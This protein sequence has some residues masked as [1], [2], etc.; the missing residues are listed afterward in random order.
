MLFF[1]TC[2]YISLS[3]IR[4]F[5]WEGPLYG[6]PILFVVGLISLIALFFSGVTGRIELFKNK[7]DVMMV[8]FASAIAMSHLSHGWFGGLQKSLVG[9]FPTFACYFMVAHSL[10]TKRKI[11]IFIILLVLLT[12]FLAYEGWLQYERGY[13]DGGVTPIHQNLFNKT[14]GEIEGK[15]EGEMEGGINRIR[16]YGMFNDP[17]DLGLVFVLV[18]PFILD[19][20]F[21]KKLILP[22]FCLPFIGTAIYL[23]HSR[24]TLLASLASIFCYIV[25]RYKS[26][27]GIILGIIVSALLFTLGSHGNIQISS[28]EESAHQRL[29]VWY[30]GFQMFK[31]N[32]FFGVGHDRFIDFNA[33]GITAHNSYMLVLCELGFFGLFFFIGLIYIPVHWLLKRLFCSHD[34][35]SRGQLSSLAAAL[36]G[37]LTA[38]F[39]L[40]RSYVFAP[41]MMIAICTAWMNSDD[42]NHGNEND[43]YIKHLKRIFIIAVSIV[44]FINIFVKIL[45]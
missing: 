22:F 31:A 1:L 2:L 19:M 24:G 36:I 12:T 34:E 37:M 5:E 23:T 40:S 15:M 4:P 44:I 25:I 43:S 7:T 35:N 32:P 17:N 14:T 13:A 27:K 45:I 16:W 30:E 9:F 26:Y 6:T 18:L 8:G 39:F 42:N 3:Y 10:N 21:N 20:I 29:D 33:S 11:S 38:M 41:F 28:S